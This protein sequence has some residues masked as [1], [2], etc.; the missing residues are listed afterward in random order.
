MLAKII[1]PADET[2]II[3]SRT[4]SI[5]NALRN[6]LRREFKAKKFRVVGSFA[7]HTNIRDNREVDID[8]VFD[9]DNHS[10]S[11]I[12]T[13]LKRC[14]EENHFECRIILKN[15][16]SL[17]QLIFRVDSLDEDYMMD[18]KVIN[19]YHSYVTEK[20]VSKSGRK[21]YYASRALWHVSLC[22]KAQIKCKFT[23]N[24]IRF[25][26]Y[27]TQ[28]GLKSVW[29]NLIVF[30]AVEKF[31]TTIRDNLG[32]FVETEK[33]LTALLKGKLILSENY[34]PIDYQKFKNK[35]LN[36]SLKLIDPSE[37]VTNHLAGISFIPSLSDKDIFCKCHK[38]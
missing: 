5:L 10:D 6:S 31:D 13:E 26:K 7:C 9:D 20:M 2:N 19:K 12:I 16:S 29:I 18:I 15:G 38:I 37:P 28:G 22:N 14:V 36:D 35:H 17:L 8:A 32:L 3:L 4:K 30:Y 33:V 11:E 21:K 23:K 25:I 24:I 27:E 1:V 34:F